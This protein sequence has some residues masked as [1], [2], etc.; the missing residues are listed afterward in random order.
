MIYA[1]FSLIKSPGLFWKVIS[2]WHV[3]ISIINDTEGVIDEMVKAKRVL[4]DPQECGTIAH[5]A[6]EFLKIGLIN[7]PFI[8]DYQLAVE[9]DNFSASLKVGVKDNIN[10]VAVIISQ[11]TGALK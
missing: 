1:I 8:D 5:C 7:V 6:S 11:K 3:I 10:N 9:I 2:N 4:P